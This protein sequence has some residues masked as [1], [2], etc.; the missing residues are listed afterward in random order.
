MTVRLK[1][2]V[3]LIEEA[4]DGIGLSKTERKVAAH[5]ATGMTAKEVAKE[6]GNSFRTIEIHVGAVKRELRLGSIAELIHFAHWKMRS[7]GGVAEV[8]GRCLG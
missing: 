5:I 3:P 8:L 6:L 2:L 4:L 1:P 7:K